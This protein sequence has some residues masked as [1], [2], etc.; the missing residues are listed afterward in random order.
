MPLAI[1]AQQEAVRET[2]MPL[3]PY[4]K[5]AGGGGEPTEL[6]PRS[7]GSRFSGYSADA[8]GL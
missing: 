4:L 1:P 5:G 2:L 8:P 7:L 3:L 6:E